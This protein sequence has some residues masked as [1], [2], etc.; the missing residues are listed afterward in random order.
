LLTD[1]LLE[2]ALRPTQRRIERT[3]R[4]VVVVVE[5]SEKLPE[6]TIADLAVG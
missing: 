3:L 6:C 2:L 4:R 1:L 5:P